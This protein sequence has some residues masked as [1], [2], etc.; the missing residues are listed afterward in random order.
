MEQL[1]S[2]KQL[3]ALLG[4]A[5]QTIYNR[6]AMGGD[7]PQCVKLGRLLRFK[8]SDIEAWLNK[9]QIPPR[10]PTAVLLSPKRPV[11]RPSKAAQIALRNSR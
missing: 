7:L 1:F 8:Q 4:I 9:Q 2:P 6:R 3:A 10:P 5:E 11:G